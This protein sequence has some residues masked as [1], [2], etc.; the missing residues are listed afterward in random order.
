[1]SDFFEHL[2]E[3]HSRPADSV[4]PRLPGRFEPDRISPTGFS[5]N[6]G[7][8]IINPGAADSDNLLNPPNIRKSKDFDSGKLSF[9][10]NPFSN[11]PVGNVFNK[12]N[13]D[14]KS[15][16]T[17]EKNLDEKSSNTIEKKFEKEQVRKWTSFDFK[18]GDL[19]KRT[20]KPDKP[21]SSDS[22]TKGNNVI[23]VKPVIQDI[24]PIKQLPTDRPERRDIQSQKPTIK[25]VIPEKE[26]SKSKSP[27]VE[28]STPEKAGQFTLTERFNTWMDEPVKEAVR[29]ELKSETLPTIQVKIGRIEV[30]AITESLPSPQVRKTAFSP[31][32]SLTEYL[33]QKNGGKR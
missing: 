16:D 6:D 7:E 15:S 31:K 17:I 18:Y 28:K 30:K 9:R 29:P 32:L 20:L 13:L 12:K 23:E 21:I 33:E 4:R 14:E 19:D 11:S 8:Q 27:D 5:D 25:P 2:I 22:L 1:M 10:Q 3:R 26:T 24:Y